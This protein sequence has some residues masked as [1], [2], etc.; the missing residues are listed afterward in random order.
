MSL[1]MGCLYCPDGVAGCRS[2]HPC[3]EC[4][5]CG[6]LIT[7]QGSSARRSPSG[8]SHALWAGWEGIRCPS[9]LT[10][11]EPAVTAAPQRP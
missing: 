6:L 9:R 5:N 4:K 3:A 11:A 10:G 2:L 8:W 1:P 7:R